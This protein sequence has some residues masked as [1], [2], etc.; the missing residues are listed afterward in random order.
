MTWLA[1]KTTAIVTSGH[2]SAVAVGDG[3]DQPPRRDGDGGRQ[4]AA[5]D[6]ADPPRRRRAPAPPGAARRTAP[7]PG[8]PAA[9]RSRRL[10]LFGHPHRATC[11]HRERGVRARLVRMGARPPSRRIH[12][13]RA[14]CS[15]TRTTASP[16]SPAPTT[17]SARRRPS[18]SPRPASTCSSPTCAS[19]TRS[20]PGSPAA[21]AVDRAGDADARPGGHRPRARP[22]RRRRGRPHRD[23]R[24]GRRLRRGRAPARAGV[25]PRQQRQRLAVADTFAP[26]PTDRL[27]RDADRPCRRRPSSA[28]SAS[29]PAPAPC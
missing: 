9:G 17:A 24:A 28:T 3:A 26:A 2:V 13:G 27:G 10:L 6:H 22:G 21:Y 8:G 25:D 4:R 15:D 16:S 19:T 18:P 5:Q 1:T 29:T 23:G 20:I 7:T 12:R 14:R 11:G